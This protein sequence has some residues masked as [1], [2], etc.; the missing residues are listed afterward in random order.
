MHCLKPY[1]W[2]EVLVK[3]IPLTWEKP[4]QLIVHVCDHQF[5]HQ[6]PIG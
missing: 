5:L 4:L 6:E 3:T 2:R 1:N